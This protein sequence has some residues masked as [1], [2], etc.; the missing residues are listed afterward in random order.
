M[1]VGVLEAVQEEDVSTL[2]EARRSLTE[3]RDRNKAQS[4][5]LVAWKRRLKEQNLL[6]LHLQRKRDDHLR[7]IQSQL[8]LFESQLRR[9][10]KEVEML[11]QQKDATIR[12]QQHIIISLSRALNN[13]NMKQVTETSNNKTKQQI[14][15]TPSDTKELKDGENNQNSDKFSGF[16]ITSTKN[17][18][19]SLNDSD[20]AIMLEDNFDSL[21]LI[22]MGKGE[23]KV[24]RS[25]S[26]AVEVASRS[27]CSTAVPPVGSLTASGSSTLPKP[28][29]SS[30]TGPGSLSTSPSCSS[31]ES[32]DSP[33]CTLK[34]GHAELLRTVYSLEE[35]EVCHTH[36]D[37]NLL[38]DTVSL[39]ASL[40]PSV[41]PSLQ[42][43]LKVTS[44]YDSDAT[45]SDGESEDEEEDSVPHLDDSA[46]DRRRLLG[47]YEKLNTLGVA[48]IKV[49]A[50]EEIQVT[51]NR[52]MS[53]HRSVTKPKDVKYRRINKAKSRSL[54]ELRGKLKYWTDRGG[55]QS[56]SVDLDNH[57]YA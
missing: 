41:T 53:N 20:S 10:Q 25:V 8:L 30:G 34:K 33:A 27:S 9:R 54:E 31:E 1:G 36:Q 3:L 38:E 37:H 47:S 16:L 50:E 45:L 42:S 22:P 24:V 43:I 56:L 18:L 28:G 57:S 55:K 40:T 6:L 51:Y 48:P 46:S 13:Q 7:T 29:F 17:D 4:H 15:K 11:L 19:E 32:D 26:D 21:V 44:H 49:K 23:V 35:E 2:E 5:L 39:T 14:S 12:Q 52:V